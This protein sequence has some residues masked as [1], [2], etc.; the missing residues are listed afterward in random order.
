MST[1]DKYVTSASSVNG[2]VFNT[3]ST[4]GSTKTSLSD[5]VSRTTKYPSSTR[6]QFIPTMAPVNE[7][8]TTATTPTTFSHPT[9]TSYIHFSRS[10]TEASS[11]L[12]VSPHV[13]NT[14]QSNLQN[15]NV[16]QSDYEGTTALTPTETSGIY[17]TQDD[18]A[19]LLRREG[20]FAMA[21]YLRQSGLDNVL[22]ETGKLIDSICAI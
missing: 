18:L 1:T 9:T 7:I 5:H 2:H 14:L 22:N 20:L 12:R 15:E 16:V 4:G 8:V 13:G 21:K 3:V 11:T 6:S 10:P 19:M 17:A